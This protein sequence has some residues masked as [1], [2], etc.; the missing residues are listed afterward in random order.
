MPSFVTQDALLVLI[1][2]FGLIGEQ[3]RQRGIAEGDLIF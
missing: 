1:D 3:F 2:R